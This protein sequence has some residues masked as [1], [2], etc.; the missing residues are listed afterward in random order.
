MRMLEIIVQASWISFFNARIEAIGEENRFNPDVENRMAALNEAAAAFCCS[1]K[2]MRNKLAIW[3]GYAR[4][5][6]AGGWAALIFAED[7]IYT[8]CKYRVG[9]ND[10]L[11]SQLLTL[12]TAFEIAADTVHP[13]WRQLLKIIP[14]GDT[15]SA[16]LYTGHPHQWTLGRAGA[17][18][19]LSES[20]PWIRQYILIETSVVD[21]EKW[22]IGFDPR[23]TVLAETYECAE[24]GQIQDDSPERNKCRCFSYVYGG[25]K[26]SPPVQIFD[27]DAAGKANGLVARWDFPPGTAIGEFVG[28]ITKGKKE[29]DVMEG[30]FGD[31]KYQIS[32]A[33]MGNFTRFINHSCRPN[34]QFERFVWMGL[35]RIVVVSRG[36]KSGCEITSDYSR[37][38]WDGLKKICRCGEPCCR[39]SGP[40]RLLQGNDSA[41]VVPQPVTTT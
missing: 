8:I 33:K 24:C 21:T 29:E 12:R 32:Q 3:Q 25:V 16:P 19:P 20:Y 15:A 11:F 1:E 9:F 30:G 37:V 7:G 38:Y 22:G 14:G 6:A 18:V 36:V 2:E 31:A 10:S 40:E 23:R 35:E 5:Q 41:A 39:Y 26:M 4:I 27:T 34:C 28:V 13:S 17:P